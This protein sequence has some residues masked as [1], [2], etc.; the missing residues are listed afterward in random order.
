MA[1]RFTTTMSVAQTLPRTEHTNGSRSQAMRLRSIPWLHHQSWTS[2]GPPPNLP[3][4]PPDFPG[5]APNFPGTASDV[6]STGSEDQLIDQD[7]R[8]AV[9]EQLA[10]KGL[11]KVEKN[12]DLQII[13]HAAIHQEKESF[14][15]ATRGFRLVGCRRFSAGSDIYHFRRH[16]GGG[17]V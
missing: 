3:A 12:A 14:Y 4:P 10:Q 8:R 13:Y 2:Q 7:I 16:A 5:G 9:D 15:L 6:R 17:P 11:T 1:R